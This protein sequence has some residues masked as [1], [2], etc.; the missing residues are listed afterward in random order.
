MLWLFILR[1]DLLKILLI[2]SVEFN[3]R[4]KYGVLKSLNGF[5]FGV[6][7]TVLV[8]GGWIFL[9]EIFGFW[10]ST[11]FEARFVWGAEMTG[12]CNVVFSIEDINSEWSSSLDS[13]VDS[14]SELSLVSSV[15]EFSPSVLS[16][17]DDDHCRDSAESWFS[18]EG[19]GFSGVI[20][21]RGVSFCSVQDITEPSGVGEATG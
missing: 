12:F 21:S 17:V 2:V 9:V 16:S 4:S 5:N 7:E 20:L 13:E 8:S 18:T 10:F 1:S 19:S 15:E 14:E 6:C 11:N 3:F